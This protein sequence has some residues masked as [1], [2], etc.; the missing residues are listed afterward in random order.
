MGFGH[1][2]IDTIKH[3]LINNLEQMRGVKPPSQPWQGRIL[4]VEPHL[5]RI[6]IHYIK[7]ILKNQPFLLKK[8]RK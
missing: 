8:F 6:Y 2:K 3:Q 1:K 7:K 5:Q 4:I